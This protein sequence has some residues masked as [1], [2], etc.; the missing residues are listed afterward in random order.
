LLLVLISSLFS[1]V[2]SKTSGVISSSLFSEA[3]KIALFSNFG[4]K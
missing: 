3:E 1:E 4:K 2:S